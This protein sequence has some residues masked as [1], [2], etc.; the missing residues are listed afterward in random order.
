M[1]GNDTMTYKQNKSLQIRFSC[2][3]DVEAE[4]LQL[5]FFRNL[6]WKARQKNHQ[7]RRK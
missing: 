3:L 4:M 7:M 2:I 6:K 5:I 1:P